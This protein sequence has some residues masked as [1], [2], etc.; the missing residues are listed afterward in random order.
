MWVTDPGK[1]PAARTSNLP[2]TR[3]AC[4]PVT[5]SHQIHCHL[6]FFS[7]P[8]LVLL[9]AK[10]NSGLYLGIS[11]RSKPH[12]L[13]CLCE[14][15]PVLLS[16]LWCQASVGFSLHSTYCNQQAYHYFYI[17]PLM[18]AHSPRLYIQWVPTRSSFWM[19]I[20][21]ANH[22]QY[23]HSRKWRLFFVFMVILEVS[24]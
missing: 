6:A 8:L 20:Y 22:C 16:E 12:T 24:F 10:A 21:S 1:V 9:S 13:E 2:D 4:D 17:F 7:S 23:C 19:D 5:L 14:S 15:H 18:S 11:L 3:K